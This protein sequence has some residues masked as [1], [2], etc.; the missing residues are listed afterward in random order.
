[1]TSSTPPHSPAVASGTALTVDD[2]AEIYL[3]DGPVRDYAWG[4]TELLAALQ[5]REP[6]AEPEAELWLGSHPGAPSLVEHQGAPISL[7]ALLAAAPA[8]T[9]GACLNDGVA[10]SGDADAPQL[11][12]L[13]KLLAAAA[14]LSIQAHPTSAQAMQG[15]ETENARGTALDAPERCYK[16]RNHKPEM[17]VA[18]TEFSALCGFRPPGESAASF[19]RLGAL[20]ELS[21]DVLRAVTDFSQRLDV[22]DL[23]GVFTA[24]LDP[25]GPWADDADNRT[26][27]TRLL[28]ALCHPDNAEAVAADTSLGAAAEI[29]SH[30]PDDPGVLVS[31]LMNRVTLAPG[32]A[33]F[34]GAGV[35]HAYLSGLGLETMAS[36]DN[37]LRGGLT[38][39]YI[40]VTELQ[41]VVDFTPTTDPRVSPESCADVPAGARVSRF[42]VPVED[43][44]VTR[45]DLDPDS[46]L[47]LP[48]AG[49]R[50]LVC[51]AGRTQVSATRESLDL[52]PGRSAFAPAQ[53]GA[54]TLHAV[55]AEHP[56]TVFVIGCPS[57]ATGASESAGS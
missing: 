15:W 27:S 57:A 50:I 33:I 37:V 13:V 47:T 3:L 31:V 7:D 49:P 14:P 41:R 10:A 6:A 17:L 19:R 8:A 36:S 20:N 12:F 43:F 30:H 2:L 16:D 5:G 29:A 22:G 18:L 40:N 53:T 51:T 54:L 55:N 9:L 26:F 34:L 32:E 21:D 38:P 25:E 42:P 11:P 1:M 45:V 24:L 46:A 48:D 52:A 44:T 4:S 56:T 23:A 28:T 35:V 39:K